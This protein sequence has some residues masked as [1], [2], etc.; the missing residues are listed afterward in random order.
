MDAASTGGTGMQI[1]LERTSKV[2]LYRQIE[3]QIR[4]LIVE[5]HLAAGAQLLTG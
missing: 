5:G 3:A 1:V 4:A 2:P